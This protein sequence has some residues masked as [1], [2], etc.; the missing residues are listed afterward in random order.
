MRFGWTRCRPLAMFAVLE[1]SGPNRVIA[2]SINRVDEQLPDLA[3]IMDFATQTERECPVPVAFQGANGTVGS[4]PLVQ[5]EA[6]L[7]SAIWAETET[8]VRVD[9][10][11]EGYESGL[12]AGLIADSLSLLN[13]PTVRHGQNRWQG[14]FGEYLLIGGPLDQRRIR[15][16]EHYLAERFSLVLRS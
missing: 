2:K 6:H 16:V 11:E 8:F 7:V 14:L 4:T 13:S 5:G 12:T 10:L 1:G 15:L 3:N 9:G